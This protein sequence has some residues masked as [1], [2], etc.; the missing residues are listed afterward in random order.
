MKN[1]HRNIETYWFLTLLLLQIVVIVLFYDELIRVPYIFV[2]ISSIFL[3]L[4]YLKMRDIFVRPLKKMN[5]DIEDFRLGKISRIGIHGEHQLFAMLAQ[6]FNAMMQVLSGVRDEYLAGRELTNDVSHAAELQK[7]FAGKTYEYVWWMEVIGDTKWAQQIN[8]DTYGFFEC[9]DQCYAYI[10]DATG[11]GVASGLIG[12]M[13]NSMMEVYGHSLIEGDKVIS[14]VNE[15]LYPKLYGGK[16]MTFA[17]LRWDV[18]QE[19]MY[20]TW[21]GH[22]TVLIYNSNTKKIK[23]YKSGG[24]ALG[25]KP[26]ITKYIEER[27]IP[28]SEWDVFILYSDGIIESRNIQDH[29]WEVYG[30]KR[31]KRTIQNTDSSDPVKVFQEISK[32]VSKHLGEHELQHDD[33]TLVCGSL[34]MFDRT[35]RDVSISFKEGYWSW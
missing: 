33:I 29:Q 2:I 24:I 21:A 26:D 20:L 6:L 10:G 16:I 1:F 27:E 4:L 28:F 32:D 3:L 25:M 5:K 35:A 11:H 9:N 34:S 18:L 19:K 15:M 31:L 7:F 14:S 23:Q 12:T 13:V 17:L 30:L 8:G 22:E